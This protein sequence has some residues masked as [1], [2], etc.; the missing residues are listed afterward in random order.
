MCVVYSVASQKGTGHPGPGPGHTF[1]LN[2]DV[3]NPQHPLSSQHSPAG[4]VR[5]A[6]TS[7]YR[8]VVSLGPRLGLVTVLLS[9]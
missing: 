1:I 8:P 6:P 5:T 3:F 2:L 4:T 9:E 7:P